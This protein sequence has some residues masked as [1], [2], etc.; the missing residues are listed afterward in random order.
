VRLYMYA[1]NVHFICFCPGLR[2]SR[3]FG[4]GLLALL[5]ATLTSFIR[6]WVRAPS[7]VPQDGTENVGMGVFWCML[8]SCPQAAAAS[9]PRVFLIVAVI[10]AAVSADTNCCTA[11]R[12]GRT[13]SDSSTAFHGITLTWLRMLSCRRS[14][15]ASSVAWRG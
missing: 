4:A 1:S 12:V 8:R 7:A 3:L 5:N 2:G 10:P 14:S 13:N 11:P 6:Y 15:A 9:R